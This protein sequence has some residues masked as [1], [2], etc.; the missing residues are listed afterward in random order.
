MVLNGD[1]DEVE[2]EI[3]SESEKEVFEQWKIDFPDI[4]LLKAVRLGLTPH[5]NPHGPDFVHI[6]PNGIG[7]RFLHHHLKF[8]V[9]MTEDRRAQGP[10]SDRIAMNVNIPFHCF[11][12][13][14]EDFRGSGQNKAGA[15]LDLLLRI[16]KKNILSSGPNID[17]QYFHKERVS[18]L[19]AEALRRVSVSVFRAR[20]SQ[21]ITLNSKL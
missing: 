9:K 10:S 17:R 20:D 15:I 12:L 5:L 16:K 1:G 6:V 8:F 4:H 18:C 19:R 13:F 11:Q 14:C 21:L 2:I 3:L 7:R